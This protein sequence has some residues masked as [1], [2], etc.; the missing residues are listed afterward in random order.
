VNTK[1]SISWKTLGAEQCRDLTSGT[2]RTSD[3]PRKSVGNREF[4]M[5]GEGN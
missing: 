5:T 4:S 1:F 2:K 3:V